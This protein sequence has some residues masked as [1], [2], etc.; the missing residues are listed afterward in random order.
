MK[1][2]LITA[3]NLDIG[4]IE[5]SLVNL[6]K[7]FDFNKYDVTLVLEHAKGIFLDQIPKDVHI[8]DY[9]L[10]ESGNVISRKLKNRTKLIKWKKEHKNKYDF[11]IS[12][13]TYSFVGARIAL[14]A[15]V[16]NAIWIHGDYYT[17]FDKD[18]KKLYDFFSKIMLNKFKNV[19]FVANS[20]KD[21]TN[22][23]YPVKGKQFVV[24]NIIDGDSIIQK[25]QEQI[26]LIKD[27]VLTFL[28][29]GRHEENQKRLFRLLEACNKLS[30]EGFR[31]KMLMVGEGPDTNSYIE[32]VK[33][34]NL[35]NNIIFLGKKQNPFPYYKIAD[36]VILSSAFEGY[37]VVF[38]E[39][40]VLNIP[41]ITTKVSDYE[42]IDS[43]YGIVTEQ[44]DIYL[45]IKDFMVNGFTIK[46]RFDYKKYNEDVLNKIYSIIE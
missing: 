17:G 40:R 20:I 9:D 45:G 26:D 18:Q 30:K 1:R 41:I 4:G 15:S 43:K 6:L 37:P 8:V 22:I 38:N 23:V 35:E 29:V 3:S 39:A 5:T 16:N 24:N 44:D 34:N 42:D 14:N 32:Y 12:Y 33:Q 36:A 11:A 2:I 10:C 25:S 13:A 27:E 31:Y 19:V 7:S 28:N 46:E 21:T